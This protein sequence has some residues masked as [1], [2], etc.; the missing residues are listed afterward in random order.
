MN[1]RS[2]KLI[3]FVTPFLVLFA[4]QPTA[5]V[6]T[7]SITKLYA[8]TAIFS[9][10]R[11]GTADSSQLRLDVY[12]PAIKLGEEPWVDF[13]SDLKPTL[14][15][16]HGGGWVSGDKISRS[17]ELL[18]YL[19]KGWNVVTV[20]YRLLS[21]EVNLSDC[22]QDC[23]EALDWVT[24]HAD[25]YK[26][27]LSKLVLSGESAGGHLAL[28][29]GLKAGKEKVSAIVNWFGISDVK[30]AIDFWNDDP[31]TSL[32]VGEEDPDS[33]FRNTSPINY[34]SGEAPPIITIHGTK[35]TSVPFSQAEL[36]HEAL[37]NA[38]VDNEL[39]SIKNKNHGNFS[40]E[41]M[42]DSFQSIWQFL[43]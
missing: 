20:D 24:A 29:V 31:Y 23:T 38:Q 16:F 3:L 34:I 6:K 7:D 21:K 11:Y 14:V 40:T 12:S 18:P 30:E 42:S 28:L 27:D 2:N 41:E 35:D 15:Y 33:L 32:V 26:F 43:K 39:I 25:F 1:R 10:I 22:I 9:N 19:E 17:L 36:L 37:N 8:E 13:T 5:A 4:C